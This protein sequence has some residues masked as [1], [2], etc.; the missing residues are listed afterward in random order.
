MTKL[1][2]VKMDD[3]LYDEMMAYA[4][5]NSLTLTGLC[6]GMIKKGFFDRI[7]S[8]QSSLKRYQDMLADPDKYQL[9]SRDIVNFENEVE[10]LKVTTQRFEDFFAEL[11]SQIYGDLAKMAMEENKDA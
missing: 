9:S 3:E 1:I 8:D 10:L 7:Q 11:A 6:R 5:A 2:S 4:K